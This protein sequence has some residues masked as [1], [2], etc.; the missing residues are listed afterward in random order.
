MT[1]TD[2]VSPVPEMDH[3]STGAVPPTAAQAAEP[4]ATPKPPGLVDRAT[5]AFT[6]YLGGDRAAMGTLVDLLNPLLWHTARGQGLAQPSAEDVVQTAWLRLIDHAERLESPQAVTAW[7]LTTVR[8]ES[9]RTAKRSGRE[10]L[11]VE[12][13]PEAMSTLPDPEHGAMLGEQQHVLWRHIASLSPRCQ[14]LLRIIAFADRP[15]YA[16][17]AEHLGMAVGSIGP[18]RGRCLA[19]LRTHLIGDPQW[20]GEPA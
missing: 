16:T 12:V 5:A 2:D 9:W 14:H 15:D 11:T 20:E 17:I 10:E 1:H 4:D 3:E 7:L 8:R 6:A 19:T 18:T 13:E